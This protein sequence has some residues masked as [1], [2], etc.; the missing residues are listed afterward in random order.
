MIRSSVCPDCGSIDIRRSRTRFWERPVK[1]VTGRRVYRCVSCN[2][3][4]WVFGAI[5]REKIV[6]LPG[7]IRA[8][9]DFSSL[10][11]RAVAAEVIR[12]RRPE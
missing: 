6:T 5:E 10:D 1:F 7:F 8:E 3:R 9:P 11:L 4:G 2:W 12:T